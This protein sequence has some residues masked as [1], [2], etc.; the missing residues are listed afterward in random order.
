MEA[1]TPETFPF[2][3]VS[4]RKRNPKRQKNG[5]LEEKKSTIIFTMIINGKSLIKMINNK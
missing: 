1:T 3:S 5:Q 4:V 2:P